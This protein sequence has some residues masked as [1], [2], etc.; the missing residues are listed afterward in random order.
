MRSH[1]S[2]NHPSLP[3][4]ANT[5]LYQY[6]PWLG[7]ILVQR[8]LI[9]FSD[10]LLTASSCLSRPWVEWS[11]YCGLHINLHEKNLYTYMRK[12]W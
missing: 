11:I 6:E 2:L 12:S 5:G 10:L 4:F 8:R 7:P 9:L 3:N 1:P